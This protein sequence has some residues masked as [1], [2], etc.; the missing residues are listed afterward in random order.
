MV[1]GSGILGKR[2]EDLAARF[3]KKNRY[4]LLERNY[5]TA[6]SEVDIIA[7][8]DDTLCFIEVK[9]RRDT[10][11][12]LPEEFVDRRKMAKVIRAARLYSVRP[13][14]RGKRVRFDIISVVLVGEDC[15][16]EHLKNAFEADFY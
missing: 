10:R 5:T 9:T 15:H 8:K 12:G 13:N 6:G 2:G 1:S 16:I 7:L 4:R 3:L 14:H 11:H